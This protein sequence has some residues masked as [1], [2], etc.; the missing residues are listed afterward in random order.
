MKHCS[1]A[2]FN[3]FDD[4]SQTITAERGDCCDLMCNIKENYTKVKPKDNLY[5]F[6]YIYSSS[7]SRV[8]FGPV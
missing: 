3:V 8:H 2:W 6:Q 7:Q 5:S 4:E 1:P